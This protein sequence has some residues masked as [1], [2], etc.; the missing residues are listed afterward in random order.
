MEP[1]FERGGDAIYKYLSHY[2]IIEFM[3]G[4]DPR[5]Q[6]QTAAAITIIIIMVRI[7]KI[8]F[9]TG[10]PTR[11][12]EEFMNKWVRTSVSRNDEFKATFIADCVSEE[13]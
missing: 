3:T 5:M 11:D 8:R 12:I 2:F 7:W 9:L 4:G 10:V 13:I 6:R 1:C